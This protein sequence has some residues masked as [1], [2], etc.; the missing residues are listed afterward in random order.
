MTTAVLQVR[1]PPRH[2][3]AQGMMPVPAPLRQA[4]QANGQE[5]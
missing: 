4:M 2:C 5:T 1:I 3:D